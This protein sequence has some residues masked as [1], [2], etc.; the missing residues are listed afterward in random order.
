M[1]AFSMPLTEIIFSGEGDGTIEV[2]RRAIYGDDDYSFISEK[3]YLTFSSGRPRPIGSM[4]DWAI[5]KLEVYATTLFP[6][7]YDTFIYNSVCYNINLI[8]HYLSTLYSDYQHVSQHF[9]QLCD[10]LQFTDPFLPFPQNFPHDLVSDCPLTSTDDLS[11]LISTEYASYSPTA[12]TGSFHKISKD[13]IPVKPY[14]QLGRAYLVNDVW[15]YCLAVCQYLSTVGAAHT[16]LQKCGQCG[17]YYLVPSSLRTSK[18]CTK[19]CSKLHSSQYFHT[20][21]EMTKLRK[22]IIEMFSRRAGDYTREIENF[23]NWYDEL[24]KSVKGKQKSEADCEKELD[25]FHKEHR[26]RAPQKN[27]KNK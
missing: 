23:K 26:L 17:R 8:K 14:S 25:T 10:R 3:E 16:R 2:V 1:S 15:Q 7:A 19:A 12:D 9:M 5:Q 21:R 20:C 6:V 24:E 22:K 13:E 11:T 4:L 18:Y 27:N